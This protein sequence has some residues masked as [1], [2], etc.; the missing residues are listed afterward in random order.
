MTDIIDIKIDA[1]FAFLGNDTIAVAQIDKE[2]CLCADGRDYLVCTEE[3]ASAK[4]EEY[5]QE[6]LWAFNLSFLCSYM[7]CVKNLEGKPFADFK[8]AFMEIQS[9][10]SEDCN[11]IFSILVGENFDRLVENAIGL[12]GRGHFLSPYDGREHEIEH[13][14]QT[15]YIYRV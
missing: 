9:K 5:I 6:N 1:L 2:G 13:E 12:D 7:D 8:I 4:C 11:P 3:E 14:G 10:M 15:F